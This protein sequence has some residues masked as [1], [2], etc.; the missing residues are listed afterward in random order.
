MADFPWPKFLADENVGKL[1]KWLRTLGYD[2]AYQSPA[3][4]AQLALKALR[5]NRV[6]LTRDRDFTKRRMVERY[7]L[8]SSQSP[9]EQLRQVIRVFSLELNHDS[10][11]SRCLDCNTVIQPVPKAQV[12]STVPDYVYRTHNQFHRCPACDKLFWRGSHTVNFQNWLQQISE[13]KEF[14]S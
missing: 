5:E 9:V 2:V 11:F 1:G 6:I 10:F 7:L 13:D 4:D 3:T 8:L 14:G 12:R